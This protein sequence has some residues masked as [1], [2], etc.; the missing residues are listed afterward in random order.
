MSLLRRRLCIPVVAWLVVY[1]AS[2][3]LLAARCC[4]DDTRVPP[5]PAAKTCHESRTPP[6]GDC[7]MRGTCNE[8]AG[9][10]LTLLS[11]EGLLPLA[12]AGV[13]PHAG[14]SLL[15]AGREQPLVLPNTP[16]SPPPRA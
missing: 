11:H 4:C 10:L 16:E 12:S 3:S 5:A 1:A 7:S 14:V 15:P 6:P 9:A 8:P 13:P 2:L